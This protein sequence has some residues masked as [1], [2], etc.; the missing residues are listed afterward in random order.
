MKA[1]KKPVS[2]PC[3]AELCIATNE[4][5][6]GD[7]CGAE[8]VGLRDGHLVCWLHKG[9]IRQLTFVD[10]GEDPPLPGPDEAPHL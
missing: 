8:S 1:P 7:Q 6:K 5:R 4:K 10:L 3:E 2:L 9:A